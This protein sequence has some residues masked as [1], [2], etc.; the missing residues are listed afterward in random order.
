MSATGC[1]DLSPFGCGAGPADICG[2]PCSAYS[3]WS[4]SSNS[5][6]ES[7][8]SKLISIFSLYSEIYFSST[9]LC[10]L[11]SSNMSSEALWQLNCLVILIVEDSMFLCV[12]HSP[13]HMWSSMC[14]INFFTCLYVCTKIN[15]PSKLSFRWKKIYLYHFSSCNN[16]KGVNLTQIP[17]KG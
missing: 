13:N 6:S 3:E 1:G 4:P 14:W 5:L 11:L 16:L 15:K 17:Y 2:A 7:E 8:Y 10:A 12:S 9:S